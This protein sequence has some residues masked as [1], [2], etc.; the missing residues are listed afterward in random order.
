LPTSAGL[1]FFASVEEAAEAIAAIEGD[2]AAASRA[3]RT[4]AED[5]FSA[6]VVLPGLLRAA[7]AG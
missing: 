4:L 6:N 2:Y 5:V 3:A 7:G 1:R